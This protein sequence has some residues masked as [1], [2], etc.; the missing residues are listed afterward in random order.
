MKRILIAAGIS[1]VVTLLAF[2]VAGL[3]GGACHCTGPVKVIFPFATLLEGWGGPEILGAPLF[4]LQFP[5]YAIILAIV[6][7]RL[8]GV[9]TA[10]TL[11]LLLGI[12]FVAALMASQVRL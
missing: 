10:L 8:D 5:A 1:I 2:V 11:L 7:L 3:A 6:S 4:I 9:W 12:H